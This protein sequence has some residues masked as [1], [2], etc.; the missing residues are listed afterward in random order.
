MKL[1]EVKK[2]SFSPWVGEKCLPWIFFFRRAA[3]PHTPSRANHSGESDEILW[4]HLLTPTWGET[5]TPWASV[6]TSLNHGWGW[7]Q[8]SLLVGPDSQGKVLSDNVGTIGKA[9][10]DHDLPPWDKIMV[11][12][13][14]GRWSSVPGFPQ[15]RAGTQRKSQFLGTLK[16]RGKKCVWVWQWPGM[17]TWHEC[18]NTSITF[19]AGCVQFT[20]L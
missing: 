1:E 3:S 12:D 11:R 8:L 18:F 7:L 15:Q 14:L 5:L 17:W 20:W 9:R 16:S 6:K 4:D 13:S 2:D 10:D 19:R